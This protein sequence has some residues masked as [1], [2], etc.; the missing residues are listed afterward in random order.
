M[1]RHFL[2]YA[3]TAHLVAAL[4]AGVVQ[5]YGLCSAAERSTEISCGAGASSFTM[6]IW[7]ALYLLLAFGVCRFFKDVRPFG[8][9][10]IG[11]AL[12]VYLLGPHTAEGLLMAFPPIIGAIAGWY[13]LYKQRQPSQP[14]I[15]G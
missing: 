5:A 1:K 8:F 10:V 14:G 9:L 4:V 13:I 12:T 11:L 15:Q 7:G 6:F 3:F 2:F